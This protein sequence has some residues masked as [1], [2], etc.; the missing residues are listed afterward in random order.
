MANMHPIEQEYA[1]LGEEI[2]EV[3]DT[4]KVHRSN[5]EALSIECDARVAE[6]RT[7]IGRLQ[8]GHSSSVGQLTTQIQK[9]ERRKKRLM[10]E[11]DQLGI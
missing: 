3:E 8:I 6:L 2:Q 4:I 1:D 9:L 10:A 7:E 5:I 11:Q